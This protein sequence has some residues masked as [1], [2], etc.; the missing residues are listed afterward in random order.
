MAAGGFDAASAGN[1]RRAKTW[2]KVGSVATN[3]KQCGDIQERLVAFLKG[4]GDLAE[5]KILPAVGWEVEI[6]QTEPYVLRTCKGMHTLELSSHRPPCEVQLQPAADL[7]VIAETSAKSP[8]NEN[9]PLLKAETDNEIIEL[10]SG[11]LPMTNLVL[12]HH[13]WQSVRYFQEIVRGLGPTDDA[14]FSSPHLDF[15]KKPW[16]E[17]SGAPY[18]FALSSDWIYGE[19]KELKN[20]NNQVQKV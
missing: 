5:D 6:G 15:C 19:D 1:K 16:S 11:P 7:L 20:F 14:D 10:I 8:A 17:L 2:A 9:L 18:K 12:H 3:E 4:R 13:F